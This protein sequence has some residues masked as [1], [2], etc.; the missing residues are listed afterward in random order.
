MPGSSLFTPHAL[1]ALREAQRQSMPNVAYVLVRALVR[2]PGAVVRQTWTLDRS[3]PCRLS[4]QRADELADETRR[5][6]IET[7]A[8]SYPVEE[9]PLDGTELV[10]VVGD[11]TQGDAPFTRVFRVMGA[12]VEKTFETRRQAT[13][14]TQ[15][16]PS[17]V[18][19]ANY[20]P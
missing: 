12:K 14:T 17:D 2:E 8:L 6:N 16:V 7:M 19:P 9:V 5:Q 1:A 4:S 20:I 15:D 3:F 10:I 11:D 18:D 13:V